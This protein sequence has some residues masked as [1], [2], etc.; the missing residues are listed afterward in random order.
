[1]A[2][3]FPDGIVQFVEAGQVA[4]LSCVIFPDGKRYFVTSVATTNEVGLL[5]IEG[6]QLNLTGVKPKKT[7]R[8]T[9]KINARDILP[10]VMVTLS[11]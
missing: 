9:F 8:C 2:V 5:R 10:V 11:S 4:P 6:Q 1:M 3:V 7:R